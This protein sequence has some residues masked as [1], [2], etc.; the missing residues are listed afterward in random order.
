[1]LSVIWL[2]YLF[3]SSE[4]QIVMILDLKQL[5]SSYFV[6]GLRLVCIWNPD[7]DLVNGKILVAKWLI[8]AAVS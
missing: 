2:V 5:Y 1:M 7:T 3:V 8:R 4:I 6:E